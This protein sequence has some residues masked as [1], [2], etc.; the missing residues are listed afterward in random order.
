MNMEQLMERKLAG[1]T[2]LLL[3]DLPQRNFVTHKSH[4]TRLGIEIWPLRWE[5]DN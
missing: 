2:E 1:E 5:D 4:M 3:E